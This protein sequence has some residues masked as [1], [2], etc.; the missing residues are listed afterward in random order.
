[1]ASK[2]LAS[3]TSASQSTTPGSITVTVTV[4]GDGVGV[5]SKARVSV[6][7]ADDLASQVEMVLP[8]GAVRDPDNKYAFTTSFRNAG[9][10]RL[11]MALHFAAPTEARS[12]APAIT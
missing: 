11:E 8:R 1:M 7:G 3:K 4:S 6:H 9:P 2:K 5:M 10:H 12:A